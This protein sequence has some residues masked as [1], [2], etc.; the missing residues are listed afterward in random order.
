[1]ERMN[2]VLMSV[3]RM[4]TPMTAY[5]CPIVRQS[6]SRHRMHLQGAHAARCAWARVLRRSTAPRHLRMDLRVGRRVGLRV[7][8]V[9]IL[10]LMLAGAVRAQD[11]ERGL[12]RNLEQHAEESGASAEGDDIDE[13]MRH[14]L[15]LASLPLP[16]LLS[17]PGMTPSLARRIRGSVRRG[18]WGTVRELCDSLRIID[19]LRSYLILGTSIRTRASA[20]SAT[21]TSGAAG[22]AG[23]DDDDSPSHP[24]APDSSMVVSL[25]SRVLRLL[26]VTRGEREKRMLGSPY[27]M[28]H[29]LRMSASWVD[30]GVV[31]SKDAHEASLTDFVSGFVRMRP[32]SGLRCIIGDYLVDEGLGSLS[33][34][35][36]RQSK[37]SATTETC[38]RVGGGLLPSTGTLPLRMYRG[39]AAQV[40]HV[41]TNGFVRA[42][43]G[44]SRFRRAARVDSISGEISSID[45][46]DLHRTREEIRALRP[47]DEMSILGGCD[48]RWTSLRVSVAAMRR[49]YDR[50]L[51]LDETGTARVASGPFASAFAEVQLWSGRTRHGLGRISA[52]GSDATSVDAVVNAELVRDS[53]GRCGFISTLVIDAAHS[54]LV[55]RARTAHPDLRPP[56]GSALTEFGS[57]GNEDGVYAGLRTRMAGGA[58]VRAYADVFRSRLPR[59]LMPVP[60]SGIELF[61]EAAWNVSSV[62]SLRVRATHRERTESER[63]ADEVLRSYREAF[64]GGRVVVD[65]RCSEALHLSVRADI[66]S[67]FRVRS[68]SMPVGSAIGFEVDWRV[69]PFLRVRARSTLFSTAGYAT[70]VSVAEVAAPGSMRLVPLYDDGMRSTCTVELAP[71][72]GFRC[73]LR[74]E[75]TEKNSTTTMG[76]SITETQGA[77]Q[78]TVL[79]QTELRL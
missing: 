72:D 26:D 38:M 35:S 6:V 63:S 5:R 22:S 70:A 77:R 15:D 43:C 46:T 28:T 69:N 53:L 40:D 20:T 58:T 17:F 1:M 48:L 18:S 44:Y 62:A 32:L 50:P 64:S 56:M 71:T 23:I 13:L 9:C 16:R 2:H 8:L 47:V 67:R 30:L 31:C 7:G 37:G 78:R 19:P 76:S 73:W 75:M 12:E 14:P 54:T 51:A 66:V 61:G 59:W 29:R 33:S 3:L 52:E 41:W 10:T 21:S 68:D 27:D 11:V 55:V 42:W 79:L 57:L 24:S 65:H 4:V 39:I 49:G 34:R 36:A 60:T 74:L 25:R 45:L